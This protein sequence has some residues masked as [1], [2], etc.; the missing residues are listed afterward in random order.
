[1]EDGRR[2]HAVSVGMLVNGDVLAS[3]AATYCFHVLYKNTVTVPASRT[4][5]NESKN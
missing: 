2:K 4:Q 1:M 5:T 3:G